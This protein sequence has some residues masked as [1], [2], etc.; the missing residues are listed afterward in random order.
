MINTTQDILFLVLAAS[1]AVLT[2]FIVWFL[3]TLIRILRSV[4]NTINSIEERIRRADEVIRLV[5]DKL[6]DSTLALTALSKTVAT[7]VRYFTEKQRKA[8][9][10]ATDEDAD[11][12]F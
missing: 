12:E 11:E 2:F 10:K 8:K 3:S 4:A 7:V 9:R 1:A 6:H 5:R